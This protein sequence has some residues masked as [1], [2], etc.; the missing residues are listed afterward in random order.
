[1]DE[2]FD[3]FAHSRL[4]GLL[5]LAGVLAGDRGIAEDVVQEVLFRVSNS[6]TMISSRDA[7]D[8]YVRRMVVNEYLSWRRKWSR[9]VPVS[10]VVD[11]RSAPDHADQ[12]ADR[13]DVS[14]RLDK[15]PA[16]QRSVLVLRYYEGL[17]DEAIATILGCS[18]GTVRSHASRGLASLRIDDQATTHRL[19]A[20]A[21]TA[22]TARSTD[23]STDRR[24]ASHADH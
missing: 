21:T 10:D 24:D 1:M 13:D 6:W 23:S 2:T 20:A 14:R 12:H 18:I 5:R 22:T 16:R 11:E 15:L 19:P 8:S 9:I 4:P 7:P 17:T 3:Q